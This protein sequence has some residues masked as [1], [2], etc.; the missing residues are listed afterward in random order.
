MSNSFFDTYQNDAESTAIYP[1]NNIGY[2]YP[3]MGLAEEAS[4]VVGKVADA[5]S[6][7]VWPCRLGE[8]S[9]LV[10]ELGDVMW[11][12][13]AIC[14]DRGI[15]LAWLVEE[16]KNYKC[17]SAN[18]LYP[19][20]A[21]AATSGDLLGVM[22]KKVRKGTYPQVKVWEDQTARTKESLLLID[23]IALV[24]ISGNQLRASLGLICERNIS[25][26]KDRQERGKIDGSGDNR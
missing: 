22:A 12:V 23:I 1:Q 2:L 19:W 3:Y 9:E 8:E 16:S 15:S 26:L 20:L 7:G 6:H 24:R 10:K 13:S 5:I 4:E 11:M 21:L 17:T 25:K 18:S 14:T